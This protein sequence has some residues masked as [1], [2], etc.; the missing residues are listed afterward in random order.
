MNLLQI[1]RTSIS[2]YRAHAGWYTLAGLGLFLTTTVSIGLMVGAILFDM[3]I[4]LYFGTDGQWIKY[5][6]GVA[7]VLMTTACGFIISSFL[8]FGGLGAFVHFCAQIGAGVREI[9]VLGYLEYIK[10]FGGSFWP[11]GMTQLITGSVVA[12]P[13]LIVGVW[14]TPGWLVLTLL[15]VFI[16]IFAFAVAQWPF[17]L[18]FGAQVVE[19]KGSITSLKNALGVSLAAP[20]TT[21][22]GV[23]MLAVLF[24]FPLPMLIF[25]PIYFFFLLAPFAA[26]F[27]VVYYEAA[28]GMIQ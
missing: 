19:R 3:I 22:A 12:L 6:L 5:P 28:K 21:M 16:S 18:A 20:A 11:I 1:I 24:T 9:T 2:L 27:G 25:Y 7:A 17:W 14:L 8:L 13:I 26:I 15:A 23:L 10:R 4:A